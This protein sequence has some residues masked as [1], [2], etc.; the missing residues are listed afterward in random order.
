[1]NDN[2]KKVTYLLFLTASNVYGIIALSVGLETWS[3]IPILTLNFASIFVSSAYDITF[4]MNGAITIITFCS[5]IA[6]FIILKFKPAH[7][8][9]SGLAIIV[10]YGGFYM[11]ILFLNIFWLSCE[12]YSERTKKEE[13]ILNI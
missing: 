13:E 9:I 10:L 1:M 7:F 3:L 11:A 5:T 6:Y 12:F 8:T 4:L 2:V